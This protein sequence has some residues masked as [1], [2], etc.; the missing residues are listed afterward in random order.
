MVVTAETLLAEAVKAFEDLDEQRPI[1]G[2]CQ[3]CSGG[4]TPYR[5]ETGPC[6]YHRAEKLLN[7]GRTAHPPDPWEDNPEFPVEDWRYEVANDDTRLGYLEWIE[8][9]RESDDNDE[10]D[11]FRERYT[12]IKNH[13]D[14]NASGDGFMF[15]TYG[16][17]V[18]FIKQQ[19]PARIWTLVDADGQSVVVAGWHYV[20]RLGYFLTEEDAKDECESY[21]Y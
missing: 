8:H 20:N 14:E 6:W 2:G 3:D 17:E 21:R 12:L 15:E 4:N 16:A 10:W 13:L 7:Q 1:D 5:L 18:E 9:K 19:P 11:K